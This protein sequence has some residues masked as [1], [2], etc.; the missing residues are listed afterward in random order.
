MTQSN[1]TSP[2]MEKSLA[3]VDYP[4]DKRQV[5]EYAR[6]QEASQEVISALENIPER[7]YSDAQDLMSELPKAG[8]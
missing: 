2:D 7:E 6:K 4:V 5:I 1:P 3:G 8:E